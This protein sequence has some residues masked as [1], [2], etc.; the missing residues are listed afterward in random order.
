MSVSNPPDY[1]PLLEYH[2][3]WPERTPMGS[4]LPDKNNDVQ[5][6]IAAEGVMNN[7]GYGRYGENEMP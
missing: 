6:L 1:I 4:S 3:L 7:P 2:D 5:F